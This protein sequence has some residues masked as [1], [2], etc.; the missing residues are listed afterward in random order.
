[1]TSVRKKAMDAYLKSDDNTGKKP[2]N[3]VDRPRLA[4]VDSSSMISD[5]SRSSIVFDD[6]STALSTVASTFSR[7]AESTRRKKSGSTSIRSNSNSQDLDATSG[8]GSIAKPRKS[9]LPP[10]PIVLPC[11]TSVPLPYDTYVPAPFVSIGKNIDPFRTMFQSSHPSVSVEELK[12]YC[13]RYFGTRSLGR[14]WI[15]TALSHAHTF[16]GTLCLAT[17]YHDVM[18]ELPLESVQTIALRQE[19]IHLVGRNMLNPQASVSDHNIM[20]V[21][22][23][24]ISEVIGREEAG[25]TWHESGIETMVAQRGGLNQLGV[26]GRLASSIAWVSLSIAVLREEQPRSTYLDYC[27]ANSMKQYQSTATIPES[28]I[29]C[30]RSTFKTIQLSSKCTP[31]AQELLS[32]I[33]MMIDV[34]LHETKQTRRN[35]QT[36]MNLYKKIIST[37]E[38]PSAAELRESQVLTQHDWKYEAIRI[39]SII[40]ATAIVHRIPL[41]EALEHAAK[42]Q[43]HSPTSAFTSTSP[44]SYIPAANARASITSIPSIATYSESSLFPASIP[45]S[46]QNPSTNLLTSLRTAIESSNTSECWS[47]MAGTLLWVCLVVGAASK[48]SESKIMKKYFSAL[49]MRAGIMLCFEHPEAINSTVAR[50]C[51]IVEALDEGDGIGGEDEG[52]D[53]RGGKDGNG[54][55]KGK[56]RRM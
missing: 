12:F 4:S 52:S 16:L 19:V 30:P 48:N 3:S 45:T 15:P 2:R 13:S 20:A 28:P 24:I 49:T 33:R 8:E 39:A 51:A 10:A 44:P 9:I 29:Y 47:E 53:G 56:K 54:K 38:Y 40:Q 35:S 25:L 41:S 14:Y 27:V 36:L 46:A 50:M 21:I 31:K 42:S 37:A 23:L 5:F 18:N 1:M 7:S 43:T 11:R 34:F 32:D 22:Q 26:H 6:T 55:G 17:A